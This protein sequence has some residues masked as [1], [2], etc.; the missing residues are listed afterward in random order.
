MD[1]LH[2]II[3]TRLNG[4]QLKEFNKIYY[5]REDH[6]ELKVKEST[7]KESIKNNFDVSAYSFSAQSRLGN[8]MF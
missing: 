7:I 4:E 3:K 6:C 8:L 5:G 1:T 2:N